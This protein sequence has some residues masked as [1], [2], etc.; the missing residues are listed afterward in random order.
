MITKADPRYLSNDVPGNLCHS[1]DPYVVTG[2]SSS[3]FTFIY[4]GPL[5][6][7]V[8]EHLPGLDRYMVA[9][10]S[11]CAKIFKTMMTNGS[12]IV[13]G[14]PEDA[15]IINNF[16]DKTVSDTP[17]PQPAQGIPSV[18]LQTSTQHRLQRTAHSKRRDYAAV[19]SSC[20]SP[21]SAVPPQFDIDVDHIG[22]SVNQRATSLGHL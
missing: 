3:V 16:T 17:S 13:V 5:D 9:N 15:K 11:A 1:F 4:P 8:L 18:A 21:S 22:H 12:R 6:Q 7:T 14:I 19:H 20:S 2:S 10:N